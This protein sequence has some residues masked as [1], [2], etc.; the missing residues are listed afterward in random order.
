MSATGGNGMVLS[1]AL[2]DLETHWEI[3]GCRW[4]DQ[5]R[6]KFDKEC[7]E[8]LRVGVRAASNAIAQ[9]EVLLDQVRRECS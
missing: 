2:K 7:L 8:E 3:L 1:G 4:K 9:I 6:E 5:A